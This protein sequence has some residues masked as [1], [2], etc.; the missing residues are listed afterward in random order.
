LPETPNRS[1][2][3][4]TSAASASPAAGR[5]L[6][7]ERAGAERRDRA[8]QERHEAQL[9]ELAEQHRP[10]GSVPVPEGLGEDV[11]A[12]AVMRQPEIEAK[13]ARKGSHPDELF[14]S[15]LTYHSLDEEE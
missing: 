11:D 8:A 9:A 7:A 12:V 1:C 3:Q 2:S 6:F 4:P 5:A 14:A 10:V 13:W 15:G